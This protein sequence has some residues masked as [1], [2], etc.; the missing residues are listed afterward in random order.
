[1]SESKTPT[2]EPVT[3][4]QLDAYL[5]LAEH[6]RERFGDNWRILDDEDADEVSVCTEDSTPTFFT[7]L[8]ATSQ[9]HGEDPLEVA[10]FL[11]AAIDYVPRMASRIRWAETER[12]AAREQA[13][14]VRDLHPKK[15]HPTYGCCG[16]PKV[17]T[18]PHPAICNGASHGISR[19]AWPCDEIR[20]LDG[21]EAGS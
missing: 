16:A 15:E 9:V 18:E 8:F 11:A 10:G 13:Q 12:N 19:P 17:C 6:I 4:E 1:M 7:E 21:T 3:D 5:Q 20:A 2:P 14:R